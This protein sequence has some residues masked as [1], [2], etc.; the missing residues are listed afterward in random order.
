MRALTQP[1]T[2]SHAHV[3][4][5][6]QPASPASLPQLISASG[7]EAHAGRGQ[8]RAP[9]DNIFT[10]DV[11][12]CACPPL[13]PRVAGV[14]ACVGAARPPPPPLVRAWLSRC[15]PASLGCLQGMTLKAMAQLLPDI[16]EEAPPPR[17]D[18]EYGL[19]DLADE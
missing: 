1:T 15:L 7:F 11:R 19:E 4:A 3:H 12:H 10:E 5:L 18:G 8:R 17:K 14:E 6:T 13:L 9:Y 2:P 16:E